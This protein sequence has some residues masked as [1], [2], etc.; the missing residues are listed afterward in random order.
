M[1]SCSKSNSAQEYED[2]IKINDVGYLLLCFVFLRFVEHAEVDAW[3]SDPQFAL[4]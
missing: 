4:K 2:N 1:R 3:L